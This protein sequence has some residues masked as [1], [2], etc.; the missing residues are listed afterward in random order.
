MTDSADVPNVPANLQ[1]G[2]PGSEFTLRTTTRLVDVGLV[3]Y[4]KK[5][6]PVTD[7]KQGDF[8]IYDNGRKLDSKYFA[9]ASQIAAPG[10]A[11]PT[12]A[13]DP[14]NPS[15]EEVI[16]NRPAPR[17]AT[18]QTSPESHSSVLLIDAA[19]L[20]WGDLS[21][22]REEM[23]RFLKTVPADEPVGLYL[24]R[25][26]GFQILLEPTI[27]RAQI[28]N[29]L[30]HWMPDAHDLQRA[31]DEERLNRQQIEYVHRKEDLTRVNGHQ[32][33]TD[34]DS[35]TMP[36]DPQ[37][38]GWGRTPGQDALSLLVGVA[39]HL[40]AFSGHKN[41][42]WVTSDWC[43]PCSIARSIARGYG[44]WSRIAAG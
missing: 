29:T 39:R 8:E 28:A 43:V 26:F 22:A 27:D 41:L 25:S 1:A 18:S 30:T 3:A 31:Q 38:R 12:G 34:Q 2:A 40:A 24:L 35:G 4:D 7:L 21:Y 32:D 37:L 23:L 9:Q 36:V 42:V 14:E 10:P 6:H 20:A 5:G 16:T 44:F 17:A 33:P 19:N 15:G 11:T 13:G